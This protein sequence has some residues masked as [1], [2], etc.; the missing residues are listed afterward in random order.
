[1]RLKDKKLFLLDLDGTLYIEE[2]AFPRTK[3]F[4]DKV[5]ENK[6]QYIYLSNNSSRGKDAYVSKMER[7][8]IQADV[9]EF[10]S[11]VDVTIDYLQ[12]KYPEGTRIFLVGTQTTADQ[13]RSA[14]L[15]I[16]TRLPAGWED[17]PPV[18]VLSY[19]TEITYKKIEEFTV[20]LMAGKDY[21][22]T[23]PDMLCPASYGMAVDIGCY[24]DMFR[25]AT[26]R[27]PLIIGKPQPQ[28]VYKA[29]K[30]C[31][32]K[33][34]ETVIIGDRLH[35]DIACGV[36]AGIDSI[37]VLSGDH[38]REDIEKYGIQ[39]TYIFNDIGEVCDEIK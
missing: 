12:D 1:M 14:G 38:K 11:S 8:G 21:V 26:G 23:H 20:M 39:P 5:K 17:L 4:L 35:T 28:M 24:I 37:F 32:V 18:A 36:N 27:T 9:S 22:A 6:A 31:G 7:L 10:I 13:M 2:K 29:M 3:E 16:E 25:T 30:Q 19:D 33:P 34:E 15:K